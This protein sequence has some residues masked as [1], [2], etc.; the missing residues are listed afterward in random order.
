[1]NFGVK[2]NKILVSGLK[3]ILKNWSVLGFEFF[4]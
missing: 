3:Y 2:I 4:P 1:M